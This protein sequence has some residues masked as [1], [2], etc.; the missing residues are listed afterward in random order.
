MGGHLAVARSAFGRPPGWPTT[1]LKVLA[2]NGVVDAGASG[3]MTT[4][5]TPAEMVA[6]A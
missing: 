3:L 5:K 1:G 6:E 2:R 4:L